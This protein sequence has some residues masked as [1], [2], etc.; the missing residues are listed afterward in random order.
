MTMKG[1][2]DE[3]GK[4]KNDNNEMMEKNNEDKGDKQQ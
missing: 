3:K 4:R 1:K 2:N